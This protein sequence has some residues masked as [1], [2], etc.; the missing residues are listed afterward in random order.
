MEVEPTKDLEAMVDRPMTITMTTTAIII[1]S[2]KEEGTKVVKEMAGNSS[3][4][5][6]NNKEAAIRDLL[7][8]SSRG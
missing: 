1:S 4:A 7:K 2:L 5:R 8:G 3:K 6:T